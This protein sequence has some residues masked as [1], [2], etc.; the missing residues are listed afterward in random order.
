MFSTLRQTFSCR[1]E[2][3]NY[4]LGRL[5][6]VDSIVM[7]VDRILMIVDSRVIMFDRIVLIFEDSNDIS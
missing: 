5:M 3:S 4:K 7:I 1:S 2:S 6:I